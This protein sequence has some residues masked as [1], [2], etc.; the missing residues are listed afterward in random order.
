MKIKTTTTRR[1]R[2]I[3]R[4]REIA[5]DLSGIPMESL[6]E[7]VSFLEL[8]FDSLFLTQLSMAY[9]KEFSVR[10]TFRQLFD[11]L[12]T[13]AA[14]SYYIDSNLP[15]EASDGAEHVAT[16]PAPAQKVAPAP[17]ASN[18]PATPAPAPLLPLLLQS[19]VAPRPAAAP[20]IAHPP[21]VEARM[22]GLDAVILQQLDLMT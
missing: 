8:G 9:Q 10:I 16:P 11:D 19:T 3:S 13:L 4:L 7:D 20:V 14:L 17:V 1:E 21:H 22:D 6:Q 5:N 15:A 12:S 2:V 18:Q